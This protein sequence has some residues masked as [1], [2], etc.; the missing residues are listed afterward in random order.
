MFRLHQASLVLICNRSDRD[1]EF[2]GG[3]I[4]HR[5]PEPVHVLSR[6]I[7]YC[8][9]EYPEAYVSAQIQACLQNDELMA[10]LAATRGPGEVAALAERI[11]GIDASDPDAISSVLGDS[12][13]RRRQRASAILLPSGSATLRRRYGQHERVFRVAYAVF[14]GRPLHYVYES[15]AWLLELVDETADRPPGAGWR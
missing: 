8:L 9:Q 13:P 3:E 5:P 6:Q 2:S 15:A 12:Q 11:A 7:A 4:I 10:E 14:S 1:R